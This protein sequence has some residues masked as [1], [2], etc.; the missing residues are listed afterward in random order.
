[1]PTINYFS[2][3]C[4]SSDD[5]ADDK[6]KFDN[7]LRYK[8]YATIERRIKSF[9]NWNKQITVKELAE[10][11]FVYEGTEDKTLC[12]YCGLGLHEWHEADVAWEQHAR[13][14]P[15]CTFMILAKGND[16]AQAIQSR[17]PP[18]LSRENAIK[19][20]TNYH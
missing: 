20:L 1:M 12:F 17:Q 3:S 15:R 16:Y 4:C 5:E 2:K 18:I 7:A 6:R 13:W 8:E 14:N 19:L 10:A 11:G 9:V